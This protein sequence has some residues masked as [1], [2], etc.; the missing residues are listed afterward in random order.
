M[1]ALLDRL[2]DRI[3]AGFTPPPT[4]HG[5]A[6]GYVRREPLGAVLGDDIDRRVRGRRVLDFG[7]GTGGDAVA[8]AEA[9]AR[10]VVGIDI[11]PASLA[12]AARL[13]DSRG[14]AARC[15]FGTH[16]DAPVD[17]VVSIDAFEHFDDPAGV[18]AT[19]AGMLHGDGRVLVSFG[20]TWYHPLGGHLFSVFPWA[21]LLF[22][23]R[24][25]LRWRARYRDDGATRF[26]EVEGGLNRMTIARFERLVAASPLRLHRMTLAPIRQLRLLH[27]RWSREFTTALVRAELGPRRPR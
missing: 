4:D 7:C 15:R 16:C 26:A 25:L 22:G 27:G 17:L 2:Q 11:V 20:P 18:L 9:G 1:G 24:A 8:L 6:A 14:V 5:H 13:A 3:L 19:M 21:H 10:Q 23:E 12:R